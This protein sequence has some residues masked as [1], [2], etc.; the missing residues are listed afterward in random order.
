M[1]VISGSAKGRRLLAVPGDTTRPI[2][3]RAKEALFNIIADDVRNSA[4]WDLFAGT[5][6]VGIEA[7]S[8]GA[9]FARFS[10]MHQAPIQT[11]RK[12]IEST[13]LGANLEI[14]RG[15]ALRML[16]AP[17]DYRFDYLYIAPPQY[18]SLWAESL[19]LL[20]AQPNWLVDNGWAV[21]QIAPKEFL[22]LRLQNF[23]LI[24][25]RKYGTT[26]LLFYARTATEEQEKAGNT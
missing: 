5:G 9:A 26:L 1:R 4:W 3:D 18:H 14:R 17:V 20:D 10:D 13:R 25:Q 11:I 21:A 15:D 2:T 12:N 24:D 19:R 22:Q 23:Q 16:Q 7:L 8:R 6:A